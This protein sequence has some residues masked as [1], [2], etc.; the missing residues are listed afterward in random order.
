MKRFWYLVGLVALTTALPAAAQTQ[1]A[2]PPR[3]TPAAPALGSAAVPVDRTVGF[4]DLERIASTTRE[5]KAANSKLDQLRAQKRA[6]V[7]ERGKQVD[8]LQ[9]SLAQTGSVLSADARLQLQRQYDR[10]QVDLQRF[11][12]D[13]QAEVQS[14][15]E[16]MLH[17][18]MQHLFP[19]VGLVASE[20]KLSA[21]FT[22]DSST[23]WHDPALDISDEIAKRL[24][25]A[26]PPDAK[27]P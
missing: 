12:Q 10:A 2:P 3:T 22:V 9:Q 6:Q 18:F 5:G 20:K 21:V 15:Q 14:A 8:A 16:Q 13:A 27:N 26:T 17:T 23:L 11:T 24:D 19:I 7:D 1:Q 4:V 25:S